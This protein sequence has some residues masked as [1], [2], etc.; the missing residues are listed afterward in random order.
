MRW[1]RFEQ[2]NVMGVF[3]KPAI[4][5]YTFAAHADAA[6][7]KLWA[8]GATNDHCDCCGNRWYLPCEVEDYE[9][10]SLEDGI[11]PHAA[12]RDDVPGSVIV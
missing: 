8:A 6:R 9:R 7:E 4:T 12:G 10:E 2:N 1:F 5:V 11:A 3:C